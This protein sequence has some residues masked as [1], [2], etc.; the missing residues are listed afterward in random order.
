MNPA[1]FPLVLAAMSGGSFT[2]PPLT[3]EDLAHHAQGIFLSWVHPGSPQPVIGSPLEMEVCELLEIYHPTDAFWRPGHIG[4][5][6]P[7]ANLVPAASPLVPPLR[8]TRAL[9]LDEDGCE[10]GLSTVP[11]AVNAERDYA[12]S[13]KLNS[14]SLDSN[15]EYVAGHCF[16]ASI[17]KTLTQRQGRKTAVSSGDVRRVV[18]LG[19]SLPLGVDRFR[20]MEQAIRDVLLGAFV[21]DAALRTCPGEKNDASASTVL[22]LIRFMKARSRMNRTLDCTEPTTSLF[23]YVQKTDFSTLVLLLGFSI[24]Q[25]SKN[26]NT[27]GATIQ[28]YSLGVK[29]SMGKKLIWDENLPFLLSFGL[30]RTRLPLLAVAC[31]R[32]FRLPKLP[33]MKLLNVN[34]EDL[35]QVDGNKLRL[36]VLSRSSLVV[37]FNGVEGV[38]GHFVPVHKARLLGELP[39]QR[40]LLPPASKEPGKRGAEDAGGGGRGG[41]EPAVVHQKKK[42]KGPSKRG[43]TADG[44][45]LC[46]EVWFDEKSSE[47][48]DWLYKLRRDEKLCCKACL[49]AGPALSKGDELSRGSK[50]GSMGS[51]LTQHEKEERHKNNVDKFI[52]VVC[53]GNREAFSKMPLPNDRDE[54]GRVVIGPVPAGSLEQLP[55]SRGVVVAPRRL[56]VSR[57][58]FRTVLKICKEE[59]PMS[60]FYALVDLQKQNGLTL[61]TLAGIKTRTAAAI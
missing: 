6:V 52:L 49:W 24:V 33:M 1:E 26:V 18:G 35:G 22:S 7:E 34:Y 23:H 16:Q 4:A 8:R 27:G 39:S 9:N 3:R 30:L 14:L 2:L 19:Y 53:R 45:R 36:L 41:P 37:E 11:S 12:E 58:L 59:L 40:I 20:P 28:K 50:E 47:H 54:H 44:R 56:D 17:A 57:K 10:E 21:S 25:L 60:K 13:L 46:R 15:Y 55:P 51:Y 61:V 29:R 5:H 38:G 32:S 31:I 43:R 42:A 48:R